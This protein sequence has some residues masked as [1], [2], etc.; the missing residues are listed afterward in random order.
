MSLS[1]LTMAIFRSMLAPFFLMSSISVSFH[2]GP[3]VTV[4][5]GCFAKGIRS[6]DVSLDAY[7]ESVSYFLNHFISKLT[8]L[9]RLSIEIDKNASA[10]I[11]EV[12]LPSHLCFFRI[13]FNREYW[14][15]LDDDDDD[16]DHPDS[17]ENTKGCVILDSVPVQ[18]NHFEL[19]SHGN[20]LQLDGC[21]GETISSMAKRIRVSWWEPHWIQPCALAF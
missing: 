17:H 9:V 19:K 7:G 21:K 5:T 18:L 8:S 2:L 10:D 3:P 13:A 1:V 11:R 20:A 14:W 16:E 15:R 4:L 12:A 6:L